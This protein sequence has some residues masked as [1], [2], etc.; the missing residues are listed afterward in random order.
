LADISTKK[1]KFMIP[2]FLLAI[3]LIFSAFLIEEIIDASDPNYGVIGF[4]IPIVSLIS[5]IYIR[6]VAGKKLTFF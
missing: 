6:K 2:L 4:F 3:N 5:F 1:V